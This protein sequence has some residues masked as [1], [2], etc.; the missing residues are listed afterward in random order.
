MDIDVAPCESCLGHF[1]EQSL[2]DWGQ[3]STEE[4]VF[5]RGG[6]CGQDFV[7]H[8]VGEWNNGSRGLM[9]GERAWY[10][11]TWG[12]TKLKTHRED[13]EAGAA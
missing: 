5:Q 13:C 3:G 4:G 8:G 7:L 10:T 9:E 2:C 11:C 12:M 1:G 6:V